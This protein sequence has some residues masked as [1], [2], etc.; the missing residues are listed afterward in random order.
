MARRWVMVAAFL[1]MAAG[2]CQH[3]G[4]R[5]RLFSRLRGEKAKPA[6]QCASPCVRPQCGCEE[7]GIG[8]A[9]GFGGVGGA[10]GGPIIYDGGITRPPNVMDLPSMPAP[11]PPASTIP[12]DMAKPGAADP[13]K[14]TEMSRQK[15]KANP[16]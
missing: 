9:G 6:E 7:G 10:G 8:G 14:G 12:G 1:A 11:M 16:F 3:C 15:S 4:E 5:P 2:G 13:S